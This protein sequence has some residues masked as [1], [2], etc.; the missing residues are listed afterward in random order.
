M[1]AAALSVLSVR[2]LRN[3]PIWS[4]VNLKQTLEQSVVLRE[5]CTRQLIHPPEIVRMRADM[6]RGLCGQEEY[7]IPSGRRNRV[8]TEKQICRPELTLALFFPFFWRWTPAVG[9]FPLTEM[10]EGWAQG[11][12]LIKDETRSHSRFESAISP[13]S[14]GPWL[15]QL[16]ACLCK[17]NFQSQ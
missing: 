4:S 17:G 6:Q 5:A 11:E 14:G 1:L 3:S 2:Q 8:V 13:C 16:H 9:E 15:G 7:T 10:S 12:G